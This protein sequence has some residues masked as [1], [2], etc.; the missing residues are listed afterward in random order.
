MQSRYHKVSVLFQTSVR[1]SLHASKSQMYSVL[2]NR[3]FN[4]R[5]RFMTVLRGETMTRHHLQYFVC[6][7]RQLFILI[8]V[9]RNNKNFTSSCT[10]GPSLIRDT[11]CNRVVIP[12]YCFVEPSF[13]KTSIRTRIIH[14]QYTYIL[15][16]YIYI[17]SR[18]HFKRTLQPFIIQ[19][20]P[21][22]IFVYQ[23]RCADKKKKKHP[24]RVFQLERIHILLYSRGFQTFYL[25]NAF[26][27]LLFIIYTR[28]PQACIFFIIRRHLLHGCVG[29]YTACHRKT[30]TRPLPRFLPYNVYYCTVRAHVT[31][32]AMASSSFLQ[33]TPCTGTPRGS[34]HAR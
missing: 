7:R 19:L 6:I 23:R 10:F 12:S 2:V 8:T 1:R 32:P 25:G 33:R 5:N 27:P 15:H 28:S 16:T 13:M 18:F 20:T 4:S 11:S 24:S 3:I 14:V 34:S 31:A 9:K 21:M 29:V 26:F 22:P 30:T 17:Y